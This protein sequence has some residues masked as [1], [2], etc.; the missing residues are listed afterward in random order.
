ML[1]VTLPFHLQF[2]SQRIWSWQGSPPQ[3]L[4]SW[5]QQPVHLHPWV[6]PRQM[7]RDHSHTGSHFHHFLPVLAHHTEKTVQNVNVCLYMHTCSPY[8][9]QD[10]FNTHQFP[11]GS[12]VAKEVTVGCILQHKSNGLLVG[13]APYQVNNIRADTST[14]F[15]HQCNFTQEFTFECNSCI[16]CQSRERVGDKWMCLC[17]VK[18]TYNITSSQYAYSGYSLYT[19]VG[20]YTHLSSLT[21]TSK[22][23]IV[24]EW[25]LVDGASASN[26]TRPR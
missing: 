15:L 14:D 25:Y 23:P 21:A 13:A 12:Q 7:S 24:S 22:S 2:A 20:A 9:L 16:S 5:C 10:G 3:W 1:N 19:V 18:R 17:H 6:C 8:V 11:H 26:L 4:D